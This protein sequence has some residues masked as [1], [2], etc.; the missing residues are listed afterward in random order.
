MD[1]SGLD[2]LLE[3]VEEQDSI[4]LPFRGKKYVVPRPG[5]KRTIRCAALLAAYRLPAEE[6]PAAILKVLD[7]DRA[8]D[9]VLGSAVAELLHADDVPVPV[10]RE[11]TTIALVAWVQGEK[12]AQAYID[13]SGAG[14]KGPKARARSTRS[15]TGTSTDAASTTKRRAS[16][17]G[18]KPRQS[19]SR[20]APAKAPAKRSTGG[21]SSPAGP[22]S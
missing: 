14:E 18:T 6:R 22:S 5:T 16:T 7:G 10:I 13:A 11:L 20:K 2:D 17:S 9:M 21:T 8:D 4:T 1:L 3:H 12:A 19:G 15:K